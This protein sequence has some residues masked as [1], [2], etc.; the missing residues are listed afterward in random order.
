MYHK[1]ITKDNLID[2]SLILITL[3]FLLILIGVK[4]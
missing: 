3:V 4:P 2:G 1:L